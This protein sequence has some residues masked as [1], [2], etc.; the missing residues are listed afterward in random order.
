[1]CKSFLAHDSQVNRSGVPRIKFTFVL[2]AKARLQATIKIAFLGGRKEKGRL[3]V[4]CQRI[5]VNIEKSN[6]DAE[7]S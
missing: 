5:I 3:D 2:L 4:K 6:R 1:M 7:R